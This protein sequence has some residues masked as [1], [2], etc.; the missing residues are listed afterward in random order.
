[1][2]SNIITQNP[3]IISYKIFR[4]KLFKGSENEVFEKYCVEYLESQNIRIKGCDRPKALKNA[5]YLKIKSDKNQKFIKQYF[6]LISIGINF[7]LKA[8]ILNTR[9]QYGLHWLMIYLNLGMKMK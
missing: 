1:M 2:I 5:I 8:L 7:Y 3:L 9:S 6:F 4:D